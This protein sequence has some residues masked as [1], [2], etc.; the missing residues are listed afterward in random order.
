MVDV[1][2]SEESIE[3]TIA[4]WDRSHTEIT[5]IRDNLTGTL[6]S[7]KWSGP[8]AEEFRQAWNEQCVPALTS[9]LQT[10]EAYRGDIQQ[11]LTNYL[12]AEGRG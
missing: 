3:Q 6:A 10:L 5:D 2:Y 4:L 8:R 7:A 9:V 12:A 1:S 11:Q